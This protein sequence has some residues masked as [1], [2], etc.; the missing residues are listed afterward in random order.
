[1]LFLKI[2]Y[3]NQNYPIIN[4]TKTVR[5]YYV[6]DMLILYNMLISAICV[7]MKFMQSFIY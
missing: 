5:Y 1:M 7:N 3:V 4:C 2:E 6:T